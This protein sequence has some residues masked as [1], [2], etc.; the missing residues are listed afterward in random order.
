M[1]LNDQARVLNSGRSNRQF[2]YKEGV[3]FTHMSGKDPRLFRLLPAVH[4]QSD[5]LSISWMP[6]ID[7]HGILAEFAVIIQIVRFVGHGRFGA[8]SRQDLLS[9]KTFATDREDKWDPLVHLYQVIQQD[10]GTWGYL[11]TDQ[12]PK[13]SKDKIRAAFGKPSP[14]LVANVLDIN[15]TTTGVQ[16]GVFTQSASAALIG[17]TGLVYTRNAQAGAEEMAKTNYLFAYANGDITDPNNGPVLKCSKEENKGEFSSYNVTVATGPDGS[18]L[19]R[20]LD[21]SHLASRQNLTKHSTWLN[22][23]TEEELINSLVGLLNGRSPQG[24]HE[25]A[26]L[27]LAFPQFRIPEPPASMAGTSTIQSGF[28]PS[29]PQTVTSGL[30]GGY[31]APPM[32]AAPAAAPVYASQGVPAFVPGAPVSAPAPVAAF[33][34]PAAP[35]AAPQAQ[36]AAFVPP[37]P[38]GGPVGA[39]VVV[40]GDPV[41]AG[42]QQSDFMARLRATTGG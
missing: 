31:Q 18:V 33:V 23:P 29:A 3:R 25:Y 22:I 32:P 19:R 10:Q 9:L 26:L 30:I 36:V 21:R 13:D 14:Q 35:V 28:T 2:I 20:A 17:K 24:Y 8:G 15:Q 34:P 39:P 41:A 40:P 11:I 6:S 42:F 4:P 12:G 16:L 7:Q 1:G 5:D 38:V 27:K 37:A